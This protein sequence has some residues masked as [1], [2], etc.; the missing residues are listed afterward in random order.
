M[1]ELSGIIALVEEIKFRS[2]ENTQ[3][4]PLSEERLKYKGDSGSSK[5]VQVDEPFESSE[6]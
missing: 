6:I 3:V 1:C 2:E 5:E 4:G